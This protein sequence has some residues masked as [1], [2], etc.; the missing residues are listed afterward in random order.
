MRRVVGST[1]KLRK[2]R[3]T[4]KALGFDLGKNLDLRKRLADLKIIYFPLA[5]LSDPTLGN[6]TL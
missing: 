2:R 5:V 6:P 3:S 1:K 4:L